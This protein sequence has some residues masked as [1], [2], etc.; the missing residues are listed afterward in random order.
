MTDAEREGGDGRATP[1][2]VDDLDFLSFVD[3]AVR[4]T[5]R[6][7]PTVDPIS[8]KLVLEL[9]R[10]ASALVYDLE[11]TVHR[12][13]GWSWPGFRVL[14]VLWL[15]GP[16]EAKRVA[17]LSGMSRAAVSA[18]VNTLERDGYVI[19]RRSEVD[20]RAVELSLTDA[21]L[22]AITTTYADHNR[23]EQVWADALT[24]PERMVLI[25]LLEKLATASSVEI[26]TRD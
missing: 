3:F 18:L 10:V 5:T 6:A 14:F 20:R 12:P 8:M 24:K 9:T 19:R 26:H 16:S 7:M 4:K 1:E 2:N 17:K 11:S 23:R 15:A 25:G 13:G 21:G 22:D